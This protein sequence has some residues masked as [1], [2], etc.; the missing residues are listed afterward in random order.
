VHARW[1]QNGL[2]STLPDTSDH[3]LMPPTPQGSKHAAALLFDV[4]LVLVVRDM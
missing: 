3:H 2:F 1:P 4:T